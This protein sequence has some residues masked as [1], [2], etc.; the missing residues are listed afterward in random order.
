MYF[1]AK[2][3]FTTG[4][5]L[6]LQPIEPRM[7]DV[8]SLISTIAW[9]MYKISVNTGKLVPVGCTLKIYTFKK[10]SSVNCS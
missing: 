1:A 5:G 7:A 10:K 8:W 3:E 6:V 9:S 2:M 4:T